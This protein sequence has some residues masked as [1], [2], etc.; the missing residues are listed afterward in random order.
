MEVYRFSYFIFLFV[1]IS[2]Y[3][4]WWCSVKTETCRYTPCNKYTVVLKAFYSLLWSVAYRGGGR[5]W[6]VQTPPRNS[7]DIGGVLDLISKKNQRL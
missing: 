5:S 6:E 3:L 7:E 2:L 4:A 1:Q